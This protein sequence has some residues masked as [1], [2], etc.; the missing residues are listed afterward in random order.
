MAVRDFSHGLNGLWF[1]QVDL[2]KPVGILSPGFNR[3]YRGK[4]LRIFR[5]ISKDMM[6]CP[7]TGR[8][9]L[10]KFIDELTGA[11]PGSI[12]QQHAHVM[13]IK[14]ACDVGGAC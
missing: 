2:L 14:P 11:I 4:M 10:K 3:I 5:G 7:L 9:P 1:K 6:I 12:D 13:A 8:Q